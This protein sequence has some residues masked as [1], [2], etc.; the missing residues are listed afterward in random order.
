MFVLLA[1]VDFDIIIKFEL[2]KQP[3]YALTA[4]IIE[5]G[6]FFSI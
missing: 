5:P 6:G 3:Y 2:L 1:H 4:G